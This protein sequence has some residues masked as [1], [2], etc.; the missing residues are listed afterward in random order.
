MGYPRCAGDSGVGFTEKQRG[1]STIFEL[2]RCLTSDDHTDGACVIERPDGMLLYVCHHNRC[3][4]KT[5][6]DAKTALRIPEPA[7]SGAGK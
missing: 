5:W 1:G 6:H 3:Q 2:D 7:G 4:G